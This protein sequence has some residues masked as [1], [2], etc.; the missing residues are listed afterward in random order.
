MSRVEAALFLGPWL[1]L[2]LLVV[3]AGARLHDYRAAQRRRNA[4]RERAR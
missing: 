1:A 3:L 4:H 2:Y